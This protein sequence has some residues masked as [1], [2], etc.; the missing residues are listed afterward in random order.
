MKAKS[1][2]TVAMAAGIASTAAASNT[3]TT[4]GPTAASVQKVAHIYYNLASGERVVT[5]LGDGQTA[6][7]DTGASSSL[8]SA[9][10]Q[11]ACANSGYTTS[12]FFGVDNPGTTSL[13]TDITNVD[14]GDI[15]LD[16]VVDCVHINWVVAHAD[17]DTDSDMIGDG[18]VG[19]GAQWT[20]WDADNGRQVNASTR[21][22]LISFIFTDL[23]GNLAPP[24]SL[25]GYTADIDL[26]AFGTATD[27]SFE[28][29]D[30]DGDLQGAAFGNNNVDTNSDG[31]GD[32]VSVANA[33]R[34]FDSILDSD[35]DGDGLF[36]WSWSVRFFQPGT[37]DFDSDGTPDGTPAPTTAD[38][39]GIS[40]GYP[41]G[42]E[43]DN[44]DGTWTYNIDTTVADAGTGEEDRFAI[45]G[46]PNGSGAILYA[47][48]F[49]F[50]GFKCTGGLI[51][52][53][54][55]GY[56]PPSMFEFQLLGPGGYVCCCVDMNGDGMLNFFDVSQFIQ[57]FIAGGDY[58]G[59]GSTDFFDVSVF[60]QDFNA[61][62]P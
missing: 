61:G 38:T 44:G 42:S 39:I 57:E 21:L 43:S 9:L 3:P 17:T 22:P 55:A 47:G 52:N 58:N 18:V 10:V 14:Y 46:A 5:L 24:G 2:L 36:D 51:A 8:W 34:D 7:A 50:G 56:T 1:A 11:N 53:G 45:Y 15:A 13:S 12:Y 26:V 33:D 30:S 16:T 28:I 31:I 62:C 49:W 19:L 60:I 54:G 48:G 37:Q 25:S 32:G 35:L 59:D 29:G 41:T 4:L 6:P 23:P 20:I 27:L 40:F